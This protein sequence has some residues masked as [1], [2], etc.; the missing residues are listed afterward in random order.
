MPVW[1]RR[2]RTTGRP[3]NKSVN[4]S[5]CRRLV[6]EIVDAVLGQHDPQTA[7]RPILQL[8][9]QLHVGNRGSRMGIVRSAGV[10]EPNY[11]AV[12]FADG[13]DGD[14]AVQSGLFI[15]MLNHIGGDLVDRED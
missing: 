12:V 11:Q 2:G 3:H 10:R 15:P 5:A 6:L 8:F 4:V 13:S 1:A 7:D 9:R 14:V